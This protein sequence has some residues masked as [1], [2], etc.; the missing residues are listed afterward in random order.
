MEA[1]HLQGYLDEFSAS[2]GVGRSFEV[3]SFGVFSNR[4]FKSSPSPTGLSS[5][6][7][8][9]S[10]ANQNRRSIIGWRRLR[11]SSIRKH[12][13]HGENTTRRGRRTQMD[14]PFSF[15]QFRVRTRKFRIDS[16][17]QN[18]YSCKVAL[19]RGFISIS[20]GRIP[21]HTC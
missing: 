8:L 18:I 12:S 10:V 16:H 1:D 4:R 17:G 15:F 21:K 6:T 9:P 20:S 5:Q 7:Q 11:L 19:Y 14:S 2:T 13:A 3:S